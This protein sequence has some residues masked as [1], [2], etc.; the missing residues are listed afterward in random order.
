MGGT[1]CIHGHFY[2]P[3][4]QDPWIE[5][6]LPEG[7][8]APYMN[9]NERIARECYSPLAFAR[10]LD[11]DGYV[12]EMVNCYEWI[13]FN[14]GPTLLSWIERHLP[15]TYS[16]I[17]EGDRLSLERTGHGNAIAQVYHHSILPLDSPRERK[18]EIRWSIHDFRARFG[19]DPEG[20]WLAEAAVDTPTL[21]DL[22]AEGISFTILSPQQA[23]AILPPEKDTWVEVDEN[24][25]DTSRPYRLDLP[26]GQ[27]MVVFFYHGPLSTAVA[28]E[29]LLADGEGFW[30]RLSSESGEKM[31]LLATDGESYGHHSKFGEMALA[32]VLD[33]GRK[34][35]DGNRL[36]NCPELLEAFP[37]QC[38]V[39]IKEQSSWS[40][41]HGLKRWQ[42]HCG[43]ADGGHP[44]WRQYWRKPLRRALNYLKYYADEHFQKQGK[45]IFADRESALLDYG[46]VLAGAESGSAF[47][48]ENFLE[49]GEEKK[50]LGW[51]LLEMQRH[52]LASFSSCAW[53][54]D[55]IYRLEPMNA[56][57]SALRG[58][59][60]LQVAGGPDVRGGFLEILED[61]DSNR[62]DVGSG[63]EIWEKDIETRLPTGPKLAFLGVCANKFGVDPDFPGIRIHCSQEGEGNQG[64]A[65][66]RWSRT[67]MDETVGFT[68]INGR[69]NECCLVGNS[70]K[71][72]ATDIPLRL[73]TLV[74][75]WS[76]FAFMQRWWEEVVEEA[77]AVWM[78]G[79]PFEPGQKDFI[80][81]VQGIYA[82]LVWHWIQEGLPDP[83][84][85]GIGRG[86]LVQNPYLLG[87]LEKAVQEDLQHR[88]QAGEEEDVLVRIVS[89]AKDA[90]LNLDMFELQNSI[91]LRRA[92]I[93]KGLLR[94]LGMALPAEDI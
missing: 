27:H 1:L 48:T 75:H 92:S 57:T 74:Q 16:R 21:E 87:L 76:V 10:L 26:S 15:Q 39:R 81:F 64:N 89:R 80:S 58:M 91:W 40:C 71:V 36:A 46:R 12:R 38:K 83:E 32:Y 82:G 30:Q 72:Q 67:G 55:D 68:F 52:C 29:H 70:K 77:K 13:S 20:M 4:R 11:K 60:L 85:L 24:S 19:R 51:T 42:E 78:S 44:D 31:K 53:F 50:Q 25:L 49:A 84:V 90:G 8:A 2:Q 3:P 6:V 62:E 65:R 14:F 66:I 37:P 43:C 23:E 34:G 79:L 59:Q 47:A 93:N 61:A 33:Q 86:F 69:L 28:F 5:D 54:F 56:L 41:M 94:K 18:M 35:R 9:W 7:S 63:K 45:E 22:A 88:L 73:R 17:L